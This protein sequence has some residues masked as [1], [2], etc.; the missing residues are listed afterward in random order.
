MG[1]PF[2]DPAHYWLVAEFVNYIGPDPNIKQECIPVGCVLP[3]AVA[4][5]G[6]VST[7]HPLSVLAFWCGGL[8]LW[9]S[10]PSPRTPYQKVTFNQKATKPEGHNRRPQQK[11]ITEGHPPGADP[12]QEETPLLQGML[13]YHLQCILG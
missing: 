6:G 10:A 2:I 11:A 3:A 9:P 4:I 12:P 1:I 5:P 8:L 13:R 7:R